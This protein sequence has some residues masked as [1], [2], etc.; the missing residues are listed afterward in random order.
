MRLSIEI[1]IAVILLASAQAHDFRGSFEY[2]LRQTMFS[3]NSINSPNSSALYGI[4]NLERSDVVVAGISSKFSE[5][6][7][8]GFISQSVTNSFE[9]SSKGHR[10]SQNLINRSN[11]SLLSGTHNLKRSEEVMAEITSR[12]F[13]GPTIYFNNPNVNIYY[14]DF[15]SVSRADIALNLKNRSSLSMWSGNLKI[16]SS[17]RLV[18]DPKK[19]GIKLE[20]EYFEPT[21]ASNALITK[22]IN[23]NSSIL[24]S[25]Y[26]P[27]NEEVVV[28]GIYSR[29]SESPRIYFNDPPVNINYPDFYSV[30]R[31]DVNLN[32][33]NRSSLSISSENAEID[34]SNRETSKPISSDLHGDNLTEDLISNYRTSELDRIKSLNNTNQ[35]NE[36]KIVVHMGESIQAAI[37]AAS[38]GDIIEINSGTYNESL[39]VNKRLTIKGVDI[40]GGL[41]IIDA[42]CRGNTVEISADQVIL[43]K[44]V[45]ANSSKIPLSP[46]AGIRFSSSNNCSID[47][48]VSYNN[49]YGINLVDSNNNTISKCN[50]SNNKYE[51]VR[52]YFSNNNTLEK[53]DVKSNLY[54]LHIVSSKGNLIQNN[55]FKDNSNNIT[56][57]KENT[58]INNENIFSR[59][60]NETKLIPNTDPRPQ[61]S[62]SHDGGKPKSSH[63][64]DTDGG[65]GEWV[66]RILPV[67]IDNEKEYQNLAQKAAGTLVFNPPKVMTSGVSEW[68]DARIGLENTTDLVQDL[69]GKG[70]IQFRNISAATNLTYVVKLE[71]D[72]GFQISA[73]RPDAQ[74]LGM[75]PAVWL[76]LV[77]PLEAGNHT[78]ILSVDVQLDK[79]PYNCKCVKVTD[80]PVEVR[81]LEPS[82]QERLMG[83]INSTYSSTKGIIAF[84]A[85]LLSLIILIRQFRKRND[86]K[87]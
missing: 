67:P 46:G 24:H 25:S 30:R 73:K 34:T 51:G 71:G 53:S 42:N 26:N 8:I 52:I 83:I 56:V 6:P 27:E 4:H 60:H 39:Q 22:P 32:Q 35:R 10:F 65:G 50:I 81:V 66:P 29:F 38:P 40:G 15:Y 64:S 61:P 59:D 17:N 43:E 44:I 78:L 20:G 28:A 58:I 70:E 62:Q 76:W 74:I 16:N 36:S 19:L 72:S 55:I 54:P 7:G 1:I 82:S 31:A 80:W 79:P 14:H 12:F 86:E 5:S 41:P 85:S 45:S 57:D 21:K 84:L 75:D 3:L 9:S 23:Y 33:K 18:S 87:K 47:G 48:I 63:S 49:Y 37:N 68:I 13:T 69:L 77:K 11:S 2:G